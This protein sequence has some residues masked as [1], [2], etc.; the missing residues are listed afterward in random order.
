MNILI[1][2]NY[3]KEMAC[4]ANFSYV[5]NDSCTFSSTEY[6]V[7]QSQA[8]SCFVRC[9]KM[10]NNGHVQIYYLTSGYKQLSALLPSLDADRFM[11]ICANSILPPISIAMDFLG[12]HLHFTIGRSNKKV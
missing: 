5:L 12:V 1:E 11:V 2:K 6:K 10:L 4:G 8:N 7:L 9:M 3:I